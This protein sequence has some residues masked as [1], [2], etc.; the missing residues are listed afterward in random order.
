MYNL[1]IV[2]PSYNEKELFNIIKKLKKK[3]ILIIDDGSKIKVSKQIA[4]SNK[5]SIIRN[6]KNK[7]YEYSLLKGL[8]I[9]VKNS[10]Y[11][12]TMDADGEHLCSNINKFY[13]FTKKNKIDLL[14]GSRSRFNRF[15]EKLLSLL[16]SIKYNIKD[17]ISGFK[18]YNSAKLQ[19]IIKK[20]KFKNNFLI[21]LLKIFI[22]NKYIVK[23]YNIKSSKN[24][25][26]KSSFTNFIT[27]IKILS[28]I[29]YL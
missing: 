27:N 2:I 3:N 11:I 18:I 19:E 23:S 7:G 10:K 12:L 22:D 25:F 24:N 1:T 4:V 29:K 9:A 5:V 15:S 20:N 8:G 6:N 28:L 16:F 13:N 21:D 26:R 14:I 17:P